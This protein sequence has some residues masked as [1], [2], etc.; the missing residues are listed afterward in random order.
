VVDDIG[1]YCNYSDEECTDFDVR[2]LKNFGM[3]FDIAGEF[4]I[5]YLVHRWRNEHVLYKKDVV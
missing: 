2:G 4:E 5:N 1:A 3:N